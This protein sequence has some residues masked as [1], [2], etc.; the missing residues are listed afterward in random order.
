MAKTA[1]DLI[2]PAGEIEVAVFPE[3]GK[4]TEP[5]LADR[6][7]AY[8][9]EGYAN[10]VVMALPD[11]S[12][13]DSAAVAWSYH[14]AFRAAYIRL[15]SE[16]VQATLLDQGSRLFTNDQA[17][18]M[19]ALSE[20]YLSDFNIIIETVPETVQITSRTAAIPNRFTF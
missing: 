10:P 11:E 6:L 12:T 4:G 1:V 13:K 8:L 16:P 5:T 15:T 14:R 9:D 19:L 17:K 3:A 18:R 2:A 20:R 7:Q